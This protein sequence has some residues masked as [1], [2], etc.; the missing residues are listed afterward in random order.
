MKAMTLIRCSQWRTE[1]DSLETTTQPIKQILIR[2]ED[3]NIKGVFLTGR[4][5]NFVLA[6]K[7]VERVPRFGE[8]LSS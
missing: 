2:I 7:S 8:I 5:K 6:I 1:R 4:A 3:G